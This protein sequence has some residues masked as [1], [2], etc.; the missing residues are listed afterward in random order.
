MA[1]IYEAQI[2]WQAPSGHRFQ[3]KPL[4]DYISAGLANVSR[5]ANEASEGIQKLHDQNAAALMEAA[6]KESANYINNFEDFSGDNYMDVMEANAMKFWDDAYAQMDDATKRRFDMYNPK[7]REIFEIK[8]KQAAVEK[9]FTHQYEEYKRRVP[10]MASQIVALGDPNAIKKGLV[11][12]INELSETSNMRAEDLEQVID[13]LRQEVADGAI[14]QAIGEGRLEDAAA[15]NND[16]DFSSAITPTKRASNNVTIQSALN[17]KEKAKKEETRDK[18]E[19]A[20]VDSLTNGAVDLYDALYAAAGKDDNSRAAVTESFNKFI[21]DFLNGD[22]KDEYNGV[23]VSKYYPDLQM[24]TDAPFHIRQKAAKNIID[25]TLENNPTDKKVKAQLGYRISTLG[26]RLPTDDEGYVD[27]TKLAPAEVAQIFSVLDQVSGYYSFDDGVQ[28]DIDKL[29][30]F[31]T[32]YTDRASL[33]LQPS[34]YQDRATLMNQ[35]TGFGWE[36][37]KYMQSGNLA[38][39]TMD[40]LRKGIAKTGGVQFNSQYREAMQDAMANFAYWANGGKLPK[41]GTYEELAMMEAVTLANMSDDDKRALGI[42]NVTTEQIVNA[43]LH[44]VNEFDSMGVL[45]TVVPDDIE[46]DALGQVVKYLPGAQGLLRAVAPQTL[47]NNTKIHGAPVK[48][49]PWY[50]S[51][52]STVKNLNGGEKVDEKV[53]ESYAAANRSTQYKYEADRVNYA[54]LS[55][56]ARPA[57]EDSNAYKTPYYAGSAKIKF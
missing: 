10:V 50:A 5:A 14:A 8:T 1:K 55:Q 24:Y 54:K 32:A 18:K 25:A 17:S 20:I 30:R 23:T 9:T 49:T 35:K 45:Q 41:S 2:Q 42:E 44:R 51:M 39:D 29:V 31:R 22:I 56:K 28:K 47:Y 19:K 11:D 12:K 7:A 4:D 33:A 48:E 3:A 26:A 27:M 37:Q 36:T 43:W 6:D 16:L 38:P 57:T 53:L 13:Q 15:L 34:A 52:L 46:T 21:S 40:A